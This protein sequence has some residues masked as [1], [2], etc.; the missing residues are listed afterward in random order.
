MRLFEFTAEFDDIIEDEAD[1]RGDADLLTT[2]SYLQAQSAG[3]HLVPRIQ[4]NALAQ[5]LNMHQTDNAVPFTAKS[6]EEAFK[7]NDELKNFIANIK[8]DE[9]DGTKYVYLKRLDDGPEGGGD[10]SMAGATP[11]V[12]EPGA[13][14]SKMADK[15]I[16][17]RS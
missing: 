15:A 8:E 3:K 14:V 1:A 2:L 16:A 7:S 10:D 4:L 13:I 12:G 11:G 17:N 5:M 6:I 9:K